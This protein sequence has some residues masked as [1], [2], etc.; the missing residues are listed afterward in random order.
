MIWTRI[1]SAL[2]WVLSIWS[3][4][5]PG[6]STRVHLAIAFLSAVGLTWYAQVTQH[7]IPANAFALACTL[8][9]GGTVEYGVNKVATAKS[10]EPK[11][12]T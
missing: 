6:S 2:K 7:D 4:G 12:P 11:D 5:G 10:T 1:V 9:G 8:L 3:E